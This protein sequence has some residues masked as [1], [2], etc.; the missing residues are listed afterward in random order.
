MAGEA[1][2]AESAASPH[3][4]EQR[5]RHEQESKPHANRQ[6]L[7]EE[8]EKEE[9]EEK[10]E[11]HKRKGDA[12]PDHASSHE[13][14]DSGD[15]K[16]KD[17]NGDEAGAGAAA[18]EEVGS[19]VGYLTFIEKLQR[20]WRDQPEVLV[21]WK[22]LCYS[23]QISKEETAV[24]M[25][26]DSMIDFV[27]APYKRYK[28]TGMYTLDAL[29][30]SSGMLL[31]GSTTLVLSPPGHG[32]SLLLKAL[33]GRLSHDKRLK[34]RV[35]FNH[36]TPEEN[37]EAGVF[38]TR[39]CAYVSSASVAFPTLTVRET[40]QFACD[41]ALPDAE[42]LRQAAKHGKEHDQH[43]DKA[44]GKTTA[45]DS[46][47]SLQSNGQS[48]QRGISNGRNTTSVPSG[49]SGEADEAL[50]DEVVKLEK[51][52]V[53]LMIEMLGLKECEDVI[54]GNDLLRGVSGGQRM[55]VRIGEMLLSNARLLALDEVSSGLDAAVTLH[56]FTALR[57]VCRLSKASVIAALLQPTPETYA[58]FDDVILLRHGTILFH[59]RRTDIPRWLKTVAGVELPPGTDEAGFLVA[60][61]AEPRQAI[62]DLKQQ[63]KRDSMRE[64][65]AGSSIDRNADGRDVSSRQDN[66]EPSSSVSSRVMPTGSQIEPSVVR[67]HEDEL[68]EAGV[69]IGVAAADVGGSPVQRHQSDSPQSTP[70]RKADA[71]PRENGCD[72]SGDRGKQSNG[73][74]DRKGDG[75]GSSALSKKSGEEAEDQKKSIPRGPSLSP[76]RRTFEGEDDKRLREVMASGDRKRNAQ[77]RRQHDDHEDDEHPR[78]EILKHN[79]THE[80]GMRV[81]LHPYGVAE[82]PSKEQYSQ[83]QRAQA[84]QSSLVAAPAVLASPPPRSWGNGA[85]QA[86]SK[87]WPNRSGALARPFSS[88]SS[89]D[90]EDLSKCRL[91]PLCTSTADLRKRYEQSEWEQLMQVEMQMAEERFKV[92][93]PYGKEARQRDGSKSD[94]LEKR[95]AA[96]PG[97]WS[98]YTLKQFCAKYPHSFWRHL[99]YNLSRQRK[100]VTRNKALAPPRL[101][102]AMLIGF[103][104]GTLFMNLGADEYP[105]RFG[106]ILYML[107]SGAFSNLSEVPLADEARNVVSRQIEAG[108]FPATAYVLSV[109]IV[110]IPLTVLEA[111]IYTSWIYWLPEFTYDAGRYFFFLLMYIVISN[112]FSVFF[113]SISYLASN[114]DVARQLDL[115]FIIVVTIFGGF[116]I[117]YNSIPDWLIWLFWLSPVSWAL[118]SAALNEFNAPRYDGIEQGGVRQGDGYMQQF[119]LQTESIWKWM[120]IVFL[121][122]FYALSLASNCLL[123]SLLPPRQQIGTRLTEK[124]RRLARTGSSTANAGGVGAMA[125]AATAMAAV[126]DAGAAGAGEEGDMADED[127]DELIELPHDEEE[128]DS[129]SPELADANQAER[130]GGRKNGMAH[131][132]SFRDDQMR[133]GQSSPP[134]KKKRLGQRKQT[135]ELHSFDCPPVVL[136]WK[137]INY[138]VPGANKKPKQLLRE[139]SGYARPGEMTALMGSSGA[140]KTT[141]M[142]VIAGRKTVGT[143]EGDILVNG[144]PKDPHVW[145]R[146]MGYVEQED[147]HVGTATVREA[148]RF[149]AHLRLPSRVPEDKRNEFVEEVMNLVGLSKLA[150]RL[151]GDESIGGLSAGE[152]KLVTV[153]VELVSNPSLLFLDEPTSGLDAPSARRV[154]AAVRRIAGTGRTVVCTIHQP[155]EEIFLMFDNLLLLQSG[156]IVVYNGPLGRD[157]RTLIDY[158]HTAS[159]GEEIGAVQQG[160]KSSQA[161]APGQDGAELRNKQKKLN[162]AR[163]SSRTLKTVTSFSSNDGSMLQRAVRVNPANWMLDLLGNADSDFAAEWKNSDAR[164]QADEDT[165]KAAKAKN[166]ETFLK[167]KGSRKHATKAE[168]HEDVDVE[169]G[170]SER[171]VQNGGKAKG[172]S[173]MSTADDAYPS[174]MIRYWAVQHRLFVSHWRNGPMNLTRFLLMGGI[175]IFFGLVYLNLAPADDFAS[176]V[177]LQGVIFLS[178]IFPCNVAAAGPLPTFYRQRAVYYRELSSGMYASGIFQTSIFVVELPY[179]LSSCLLFLVPFYFMTGFPHS[180]EV[181]FTYFCVL[182]LM[183]LFYSSVL[184]LWLAAL[185]SQIVANIASGLLNSLFFVFGGLLISPALIPRGWKWFYYV[186]PVP[187]A[188]NPVVLKMFECDVD[189]PGNSCP[190]LTTNPGAPPVP[191]FSYASENLD[192][193]P[194]DFGRNVGWLVLTIGVVRI[195]I[196]LAFR[197][198]SHI[199]R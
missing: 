58:T 134:V 106:L 116:L 78:G 53:S 183:F 64:E 132:V 93:D 35:M 7:E 127:S 159:H 110:H 87:Q 100:L 24:K 6:Q 165:D 147:I 148:L 130:A 158:F 9:K 26:L 138:S 25:L 40:F 120:G 141:L 80:D 15:A 188:F 123:L 55:R 133:G 177:S 59:G 125:P 49:S 143:I 149:S 118:R 47:R 142:D 112:A 185:P 5:Q 27:K 114:P 29:R 105:A 65:S 193:S 41:N 194:D 16:E 124:D 30:P 119:G 102:Q 28:G 186:D 85:G 45:A 46:S 178:L 52:R 76:R 56:I 182:A 190:T 167:K 10:K 175:S 66:R 60:F 34:G 19:P 91:V 79:A 36:R 199:K 94:H 21:S 98:P 168:E 115:P 181:F 39:L 187:K 170:Q 3:D 180:A 63:Q 88:F 139:V 89:S 144:Q 173:G 191:I 20:V 73:D 196:F 131:H 104:L 172:E 117:N 160:T 22:D 198:I 129:S 137:N 57:E 166:P 157:A 61:L 75:G 42:L 163:S 23:L 107:M 72:S 103:V 169:K 14:H 161:V 82:W 43:D 67:F 90:D 81:S 33:S 71:T 1:I 96:S 13:T 184:T 162:G 50:I 195:L 151:I 154:M 171:N 136:A 108:F 8:E 135:F 197:Y 176:T 31:P 155:S 48:Q 153:A 84:E 54:I 164:K 83:P 192:A 145:P 174:T 74:G 37:L 51:D 126:P 18:A 4:L 77:Q 150:D 86:G 92:L 113:R 44:A 12:T 2:S 70:S 111:L 68:E 69:V 32:K 146:L 17:E 11:E 38:T 179:I 101:F 109:A 189:A 122:G 121:V 62:E 140:G 156:G 97:Q 152:L 95:G 99:A 128:D